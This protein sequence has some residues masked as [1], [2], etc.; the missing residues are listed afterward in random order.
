M[1]SIINFLK[2]KKYLLF[3]ALICFVFLNL[4]YFE[5]K[6]E[7]FSLADNKGLI[8]PDVLVEKLQKKIVEYDGVLK[9]MNEITNDVAG[10]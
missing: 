6:C 3:F 7:S 9:K 8:K 2:N 10:I 5:K 4:F 1:K